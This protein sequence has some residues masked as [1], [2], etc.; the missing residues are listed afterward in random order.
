MVFPGC[1]GLF[2]RGLMTAPDRRREE[3]KVRRRERVK[4]CRDRSVEGWKTQRLGAPT[5]VVQKGRFC[6]GRGWL[7]D[8]IQE[9]R[10]ENRES[11]QVVIG[12]G[13]GGKWGIG[14]WDG[15]GWD[16]KRYFLGHVFGCGSGCLVSNVGSEWIGCLPS[17]AP[18]APGGGR[19]WRRGVGCKR[20]AS[21]HQRGLT[22]ANANAALSGHSGQ[23]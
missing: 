19:K 14:G 22:C 3:G 10:I 20:A 18:G 16:G 5:T 15:M 21:A 1:L 17:A 13:I 8:L 11:R 7:A 6:L 23:L 12:I 9:S 2:F 4:E